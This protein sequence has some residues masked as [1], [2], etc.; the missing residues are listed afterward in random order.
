LTPEEAAGPPGAGY[1]EARGG[2]I[3]MAMSHVQASV[4]RQTAD[5]RIRQAEQRRLVRSLR[6]TENRARRTRRARSFLFDL[7][8]A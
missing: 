2:G 1:F 5:E 7:L 8:S 4:A 6:P 3:V